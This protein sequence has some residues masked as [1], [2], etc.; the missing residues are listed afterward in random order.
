MLHLPE[1]QNEMYAKNKN[2]YLVTDKLTDLTEVRE[3]KKRLSS[4]LGKSVSYKSVKEEIDE[5]LL[6]RYVPEISDSPD[7]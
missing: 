6:I 5:D 3:W 2:Y 4:F 1:P 7:C